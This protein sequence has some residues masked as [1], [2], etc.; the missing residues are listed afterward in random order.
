MLTLAGSVDERGLWRQQPHGAVQVLRS[1]GAVARQAEPELP[2]GGPSLSLGLL[3]LVAAHEEPDPVQ[4]HLHGLVVH[5]G[6]ADAEPPGLPAV[7]RRP[8]RH[9]ELHLVYDHPP[10]LQLRLGRRL[11]IP[12]HSPQVHPREKPRVAAQAPD[13][14]LPQPLRE[15]LVPR[16]EPGRALPQEPRHERLVREHPGQE[17]L[18]LRRHEAEAGHL[19]CAVHYGVVVRVD[20]ADAEARE[21]EVLGEAVGD[22]DQVP[23]ATGRVVLH[24]LRDAHVLRLVGEHGPRVDLVADQVDPVLRREAGEHDQRG[25]VRQRAQ[26]V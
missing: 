3:L 2:L 24:H 6:V 13:A 11:L 19:A 7:E 20:D 26:R 9:V 8:R 16:R 25:A 4:R 15:P 14:D 23:V 5:V 1:H 21:A 10:Q 12:Q 18:R 22:V 17:V